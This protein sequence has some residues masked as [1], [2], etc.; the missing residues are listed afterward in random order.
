MKCSE[1][2]KPIRLGEKAY[3]GLWEVW[4]ID[5]EAGKF[6]ATMKPGGLVWDDDGRRVK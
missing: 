5:C 6:P 1:C 2:G 4:H 3:V